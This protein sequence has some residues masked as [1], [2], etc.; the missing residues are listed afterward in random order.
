MPHETAARCLLALRHRLPR[1][2]LLRRFIAVD[3]ERSEASKNKDRDYWQENR[4]E[5]PHQLILRLLGVRLLRLSYSE[6]LQMIYSARQYKELHRA[7]VELSDLGIIPSLD[8]TS[9]VLE[10]GCNM[11]T[12]LRQLH[13]RYGCPVTGVDINEEAIRIAR[14]ETGPRCDWATFHCRDVLDPEC[15]TYFA[16]KHFSHTFISSHLIHLPRGDAK[17]AYL[18]QLQRISQ[19]I[20]AWERFPS[21][22]D[23]RA[24]TSGMEDLAAEYGFVCHRVH[25]K[26][27]P[28]FIKLIGVFYWPPA[29]AREDQLHAD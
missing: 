17:R 15:F 2:P 10:P 22:N 1:I 20:V 12:F 6:S 28:Q 8:Q 4:T 19:G 5:A 3:L 29:P 7:V 27:H 23:P 16:D 9:E 26:E 21:E 25:R 11:G 13:E 24:E 18:A 14:K